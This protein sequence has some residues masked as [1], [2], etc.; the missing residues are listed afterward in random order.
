[1]NALQA[2]LMSLGMVASAGEY[3]A[4]VLIGSSAGV[5]EMITTFIVVNLISSTGMA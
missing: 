4:I 2:G 5:F 1:M 3:A